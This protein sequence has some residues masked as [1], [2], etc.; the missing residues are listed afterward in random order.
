[1][2]NF[3]KNYYSRMARLKREH[4]IKLIR[5]TIVIL[6]IGFALGVLAGHSSKKTKPEA[7]STPSGAEIVVAREPEAT[8]TPISKYVIGEASYYSVAGCLGCDP[9]AIMANGEKLDDSKMTIALTP[10]IVKKYKLLNDKVKVTNLGNG[11]SI[12]AK[13]TDTGGFAKYNRVA[14]L[15]VATKNAIGC[16]SLC[17]VKVIFD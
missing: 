2:Q 11:H 10:E 13:V 14:D 6:I 16:K 15:S 9:E 17:Q 1:M 3:G 4:Q 12:Y 5:Y 7:I 8:P